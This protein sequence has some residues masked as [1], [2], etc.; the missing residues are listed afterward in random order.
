[1]TH[2]IVSSIN[3]QRTTYSPPKYPRHR[4][5]RKEVETQHERPRTPNSINFVI[6]FFLAAASSSLAFCLFSRLPAF[7][8][9]ARAI[10]RVRKAFFSFS[11]AS[12]ARSPTTPCWAMGV[13]LGRATWRASLISSAEESPFFGALALR[14]KMIKLLRYSFRRATLI[15]RDS[16]EV[17]RRRWSTGMPMERANLR[18]TPAA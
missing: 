4:S 9:S 14:G 18:A 3:A 13:I 6:Y 15:W 16:S 10:R 5:R 8:L 7:L 17:L 1:M 2:F 12:M 11:P